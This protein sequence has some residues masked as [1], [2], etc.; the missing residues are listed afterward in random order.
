MAG[1][2]AAQPIMPGRETSCDPATASSLPLNDLSSEAAACAHRTYPLPMADT[3]ALRQD[4]YDRVEVVAWNESDVEIETI[5]VTRRATMDRARSDLP[6]VKLQRVDGV[7]QSTG[8]NDDAPGWWSVKYRLRVP[9]QT[10]LV[11]TSRNGAI[12]VRDVVGAHEIQSKNGDIFYRL[13]AGAGAQVQAETDN[14]ALDVG[15]PITVQG[16]LGNR[17]DTV[18]GGGGPTVRLVTENGDITLRRAE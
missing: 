14:G 10:T 13:P 18:V 8:P 16:T 1:P 5:V 11:M 6:L 17:L 12:A 4:R 9:A 2:A 3:V 7:L 15:F